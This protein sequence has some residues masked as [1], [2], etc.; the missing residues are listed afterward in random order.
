MITIA[1]LQLVPYSLIIPIRK[2]GQF[3]KGKDKRDEQAGSNHLCPHS[4]CG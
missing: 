3:F 1:Y 2:I 4:S